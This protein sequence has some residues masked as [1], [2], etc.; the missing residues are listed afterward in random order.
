MLAN[1]ARWDRFMGLVVAVQAPWPQGEADTDE[2]RKG[3]ALEVFNLALPVCQDLRELKP[4][5]I[6]WVPHILL[7]IVP[8][9][10]VSLGD[11]AR[12]SCDA[13][14]SFGAMVKKII[15]HAT[16]RR[17]TGT[18]RSPFLNPQPHPLTQP[19]PSLATMCL[20]FQIHHIPSTGFPLPTLQAFDH[21]KKATAGTTAR[22]WKQA[23][24]VGYVQQAFTRACVRESLR[25]G[26]EN[27]PYLQ[28]SDIRLVS[29]GKGS[30]AGSSKLEAAG[31]APVQKPK[32]HTLCVGP[33]TE[34]PRC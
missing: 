22:R 9:Q 34:I 12:R 1:A 23:F 17:R 32:I 19:T 14:E 3:R 4:T 7:F 21:S 5:G 16:C 11:P 18:V 2:Y 26:E 25:H 6:T 28:R 33:R 20:A 27:A 13:C 8:R 29:K 15:K 10:M 31:G 30:L 24:S